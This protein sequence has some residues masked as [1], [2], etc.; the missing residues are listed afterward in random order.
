VEGQRV[1]DDAFEAGGGHAVEVDDG[2]RGTER[3]AIFA[4][5]EGTAISEDEGLSFCCHYRGTVDL[6][7]IWVLS[8]TVG[9]SYFRKFSSHAHGNIRLLWARLR[10]VVALP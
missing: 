10:T 3:I 1:P 7:G 8:T 4:P 2:R 5:G 6:D 9:R